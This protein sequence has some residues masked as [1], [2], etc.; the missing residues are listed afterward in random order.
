MV[1]RSVTALSARMARARGIAR[2]RISGW[3]SSRKR[4]AAA[5][6]QSPARSD[7]GRKRDVDVELLAGVLH[8][9]IDLLGGGAQHLHA[10][11][12]KALGRSEP[13]PAAPAPTDDE[14]AAAKALLARAAG[15][16]DAPAES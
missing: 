12:D 6:T 1:V 8:S 14:I 3:L 7:T 13:E 4:D 10:E 16:S 5:V 9:V 2:A 11:L 15:G